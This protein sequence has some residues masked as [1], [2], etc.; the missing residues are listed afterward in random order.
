MRVI[1]REGQPYFDTEDLRFAQRCFPGIKSISSHFIWDPA[2]WLPGQNSVFSLLREPVARTAS[3][4]QYKVAYG[5]FKDSENA[6]TK[7]HFADWISDPR[8]Q[9]DQIRQISGGLDLDH[10]KDV[11]T[12]NFF[13]LGLT[14]RLDESV[15]ALSLLSPLPLDISPPTPRHKKGKSLTNRASDNSIS[16]MLK[17]DPVTRELLESGN[18]FDTA[19][20]Q[21]VATEM[22]PQYLAQA[23]QAERRPTP[24]ISKANYRRSKF[25]NNGIYAPAQR[26]RYAFKGQKEDSNPVF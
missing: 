12:R 8:H 18:R 14:E 20:Y 21:W 2:R 1:P 4:Y 3:T 23:A 26:L 24:I 19:F 10:A 17:E 6:G 25:I 9:D 22:Y 15:E 13:F 16:K 11:V 5:R 7:E